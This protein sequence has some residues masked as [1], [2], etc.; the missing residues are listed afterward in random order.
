MAEIQ[1]CFLNIEFA[2]GD[3]KMLRIQ[4]EVYDDI[5]ILSENGF[6]EFKG[7]QA[8]VDRDKDGLMQ[9]LWIGNFKW[10]RKKT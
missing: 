10:K 6:F 9:N 2:P 4:K 8:K 3:N 1:W 5:C 7:G